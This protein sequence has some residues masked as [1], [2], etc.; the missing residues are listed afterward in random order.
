MPTLKPSVMDSRR[1]QMFPVLEAV[2]IERMW[3]FGTPRSYAAG[4]ALAQAGKVSEGLV[5]HTF[6]QC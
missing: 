6:R 4:D 3:L 1:D 2:E 5:N